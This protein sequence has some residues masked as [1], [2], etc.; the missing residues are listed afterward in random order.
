MPRLFLL[1]GSAL[2]LVAVGLGAYGAHGLSEK[3]AKLYPGDSA[4]AQRLHQNWETA[5]RYQMYHALALLAVAWVVSY[6]PGRLSSAAGWL[7]F[8]GTL[9]FSGSL[10][11]ITLTGAKWLGAA[12]T[13]L[14]G[15]ILM[16]GWA[17]LFLAALRARGKDDLQKGGQA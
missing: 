9:L 5:A 13:P 3:L 15:L 8:S 17:C 4:L 11:V 1:L 14:G 2:G 10:Y 12:V 7:F 16:A 6:A